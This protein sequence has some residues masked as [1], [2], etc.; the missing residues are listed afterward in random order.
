MAA[1]VRLIR[2]SGVDLQQFRVEPI[3]PGEP[4]VLLM[5]RMLWDKG[6]GEFVE[7][8]RLLRSRGTRARFVLV[9]DPDGENPAAIPVERL[10]QWQASGVVEWWGHRADAAAVAR[11]ERGEAGKLRRAEGRRQP[12]QRPVG[13]EDPLWPEFA[14]E[15]LG[16][17]RR[18]Q[19]AEHG[20]PTRA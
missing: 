20:I 6:V 13:V 2:G 11:S 7:A 1:S 12:R 5:S 4:I 3:P 8:A 14:Q 16:R 10:R 18:K 9:G 17:F 15:T 19:G